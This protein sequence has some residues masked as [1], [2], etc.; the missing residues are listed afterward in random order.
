MTAYH[1]RFFVYEQYEGHICSDQEGT[2]VH[3][4]QPGRELPQTVLLLPVGGCYGLVLEGSI[5]LFHGSFQVP[6]GYWFSTRSGLQ[7]VVPPDAHVVVIQK[8][9]HDGMFG[10]GQLEDSGRLCYI[11]GAKDTVL[12]APWRKGE[13]CLN[14][15]F[16]PQGVHQ[17]MHTH[18]STRI[19]IISGG[20]GY[21][22]TREARH[23]MRRGAVFFLP[24]DGWH[25]FRTDS[26]ETP[27]LN[28]VAY[29]PDSDQGPTDEA[30]PMLSRTIVHGVSAQDIPAIQTKR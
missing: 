29:H 30:H 15:L 12:Q 2:D 24:A 8:V 16:I 17:T 18:P 1:D 6:A 14:A 19:G 20:L 21:C 26:P 28:V 10:I 9:G 22:E 3:G 4:W 11:D 7:M 5:S 23:T 13:A 27:F 25:K